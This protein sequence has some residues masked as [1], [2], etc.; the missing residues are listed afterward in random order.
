MI[1]DVS[2]GKRYA[3]GETRSLF[4]P[5]RENKTPHPTHGFTELDLSGLTKQQ[6]ETLTESPANSQCPS[7]E[8]ITSKN[9]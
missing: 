5:L 1:F 7:R 6:L 8:N 4:L 2:A 3:I 9:N